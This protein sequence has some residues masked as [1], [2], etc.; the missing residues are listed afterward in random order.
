LDQE[1][2]TQQ[3]EE[4][5]REIG[6]F[7][8]EFSQLVRTMDQHATMT[9][10]PPPGDRARAKAGPDE[11]ERTLARYRQALNSQ[12]RTGTKT[13]EDREA[14]GQLQRDLEALIDERNRVAHDAWFV[15]WGNQDTT[16]WGEAERWRYRSGETL[17]IEAPKFRATDLRLLAWEADR[18]RRLVGDIWAAVATQELPDHPGVA[19]IYRVVSERLEATRPP[20]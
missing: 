19:H 15:G 6:R 9:L 18:L 7:V 2:F 1:R 13:A 3:T 16:D 17:P 10:G 8:V 11:A 20:T 5:Y 12:F 14:L 4:I